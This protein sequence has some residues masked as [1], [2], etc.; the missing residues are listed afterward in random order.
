MNDIDPSFKDEV[1]NKKGELKKDWKGRIQLSKSPYLNTEYLGIVVDSSLPA[2]KTSPLRLL[3][4]RQAINY[5]FDRK[6]MMT[7]LR[8]SIGMPAESGLFPGVFPVLI[9][10]V[11]MGII[12]IRPGPENY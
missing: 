7:Y 2:V 10:H 11:F 5:G 3:K 8:N 12:M 9:L 4:I 1:L 6:K